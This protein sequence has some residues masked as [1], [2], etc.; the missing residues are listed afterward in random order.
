[1]PWPYTSPWELPGGPAT[2]ARL[3]G[4]YS[5]AVL[6]THCVRGL[7]RLI[8]QYKDKPRIE[9]ILCAILDQVEALE[10]AEQD[11]LRADTLFTGL[12]AQL[13]RDGRIVGAGDR[14]GLALDRYRLVVLASILVRSSDGLPEEL[15]S[16]I[17]VLFPD[18]STWTV[19]EIF[20]AA[21]RVTLFD[22]ADSTE[23]KIVHQLLYRS[24]SNGVR[25][26]T[27][28]STSPAATTFRFSATS[29]IEAA[30]PH[31]FGDV[32]DAEVG[33]KLAGVY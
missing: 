22:L 26:H 33:G 19:E 30:S 6:E 25:L 1:M 14:G 18:E 15:I 29:T 5:V 20:P 4:D 21:A 16:I 7:R 27:V 12:D 9:A 28:W 17:R 24:K 10:V 13:T 31:G 32:L 3:D 23:A 8:Q 2:P 11:V